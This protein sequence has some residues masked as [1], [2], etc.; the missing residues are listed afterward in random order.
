LISVGQPGRTPAANFYAAADILSTRIIN[1]PF[2]L[3][4]AEG[5]AVREVQAEY[6]LDGGGRWLPAIP[7]TGT[8]THDLAASPSGVAHTFA[9]DSV[10]SNVFGQSDHV[11]IRMKAIASSR[12]QARR[13][14]GSYIAAASVWASNLP[15]RL[16]GTIARVVD[17]STKPVPDALVYHLPSGKSRNGPPL[18]NW[19]TGTPLP[20]LA[21]GY[22]A[23]RDAL[24]P[25]DQLIAVQTITTTGNLSFTYT[26]ATPTPTGIAALTMG[27]TGGIQTLTIAPSN[28]LL[29][30]NLSVGLEW[31]ASGDTAFMESLRARLH[32][33]SEILYDWSNGQVALGSLTIYQNKNHWDHTFNS[34]GA[35]ITRGVDLRIYA[36]NQ[37]RP[38][39]TQ[40]GIIN[41]PT[42]VS[43]PNAPGGA[44]TASYE[45]GYIRIGTSWNA[46]G[47][48]GIDVAE[49]WAKALAHE[50]GHY[51][52][53]LD[54]TYLGKQGNLLVPV[55]G[56]A[57]PMAD[58]Y[59][60]SASEFRPA[61]DWPAACQ[62]TL[63]HLGTGLSEWTMITSLYNRTIAADGFAFSLNVPAMANS[64]PGPALLPIG[65]TT[66]TEPSAADTSAASETYGVIPPGGGRYEPSPSARALIFPSGSQLPID[67]G[68][69]EAGQVL[70][71]GYRAADRLCVFDSAQSLLGCNLSP[72]GLQLHSTTGWHPELQ[73]TPITYPG[74]SGT[75][76][77]TL[78]IA[79]PSATVANDIAPSTLQLQ[80]YPREGTTAPMVATLPLAS[81]FYRADLALPEVIEEG[82]VRIWIDND[83]QGREA[84]SDYAVGGNPAP[85]SKPPAR[86]RKRAP[87]VSPDG[88]ATLFAED[89]VFAPG[90][91]FALQRASSLP[92]LP[93]WAAPVGQGYRLLASDPTMLS[94]LNNPIALSLSYAQGDVPLGLEGDVRVLFYD[95]TSWAELPTRVDSARNEA[96]ISVQPTPG[97]YVLITSLRLSI[98]RPGW[99]LLYAY[100]G[101]TQALPLALKSAQDQGAYD[102]VYGYSPADTGDPWKVFSPQVPAWVNDLAGLE[103]GTSYWLHLLTPATIA[104]PIPVA[105]LNAEG[106]LPAPPSTVYGTL[107]A[108]WGFS[109]EADLTVQAL[110]GTTICGSTTSRDIGGGKIGF[111]LDSV[112]LDGNALGCGSNGEAATI[113]V[114]SGSSILKEVRLSW[115]NDQIREV[116][117]NGVIRLNRAFLPLL[118][119]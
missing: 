55:S 82:L 25:G 44:R 15:F 78:R 108:S 67:L 80:L 83:P 86:S 26:S 8:I 87:A 112:A 72:S 57:S 95:G 7:A 53:Y 45:P 110:V 84:V 10:A 24:K 1:I 20:S 38:N 14:A 111:V 50:V 62:T 85:R 119:R 99:S 56:C 88:Q 48:P 76:T 5:D 29:L 46:N 113:Q 40:G 2:T 100:P 73:I 42:T 109:P 28:P 54:E 74:A 90:Q 39:A 61:S 21:S 105:N 60:D 63:Q 23:S 97:I 94:N 103:E 68:A 104:L 101:A 13:V 69:P 36:S 3:A 70:A 27:T 106:L 65:V 32:R 19:L 66:I 17:T 75:P 58:P 102:M 91:F 47:D 33:T 116:G 6:S 64:N 117:P 71:R 115:Q 52:F 89:S 18:Q 118:S 12:P 22:V 51:A 34:Q 79:I 35:V 9:W 11:I 77:M 31:D 30:L 96:A 4:D 107:D 81:G 98:V 41:R 37:I 43:Y 49:D 92:A 59:T 16:I 114:L 93:P